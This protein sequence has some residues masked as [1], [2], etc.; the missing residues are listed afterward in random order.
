MK[1][2]AGIYQNGLRLLKLINEL[3]NLSSVDAGRLR[4]EHREFRLDEFLDRI[5]HSIRHMAQQGG[6]T[7]TQNLKIAAGT[8]RGDEEKL[9]KILLNLLFNAVKFTPSG[10]RVS[11]G[12]RTGAQRSH[13]RSQRHRRGHPCQEPALHLR[14]VLAGGHLGH[15]TPHGHRPRPVPRE[16]VHPQLGGRVE[17]ESRIGVGTTLRVIL[18]CQQRNAIPVFGLD[19]KDSRPITGTE[20]ARHIRSEPRF[21]RMDPLDLPR[22]GSGRRGLP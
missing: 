6:V 19:F 1:K 14:P 16:G 21:G 22:S 15:A 9:E 13:L 17:A 11:L 18:P 12:I 10:G 4:I 20:A 7:V 3:L 5:T 8:V 2:S